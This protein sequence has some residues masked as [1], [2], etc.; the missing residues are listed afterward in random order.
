M[1]ALR[2]FISDLVSLYQ[3][4]RPI[5]II[6]WLPWLV[7]VAMQSRADRIGVGIVMAAVTLFGQ[8]L[9][10]AY[11][12]SLRSRMIT[13]D[14]NYWTVEVDGTARGAISDA[15]YA[16]MRERA[17]FSVS[18][19]LRQTVNV[20]GAGVTFLHWLIRNIPVILFWIALGGLLLAPEGTVVAIK[21]ILV[22]A[23]TDPERLAVAI[24]QF[25]LPMLMS[26][27]ALGMLFLYQ[28][29]GYRNE[30]RAAWQ[31]ELRR[32]LD[33]FPVGEIILTRVENQQ[34]V[35]ADERRAYRA[36]LRQ[37]RGLAEAAASAA[38]GAA[39]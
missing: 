13:S 31:D 21:T 5:A 18:T 23:Q 15:E 37:R 33:L 6:T 32:R 7:A 27:A 11:S 28:Q 34:T 19:Y 26:S 2:Q 10:A 12:L 20:V 16:A 17:A 38:E 3:W 30:F 25:L 35:I 8:G 36:F 39:R 14:D 1:R 4:R 9:L 29:F 22:A 24:V